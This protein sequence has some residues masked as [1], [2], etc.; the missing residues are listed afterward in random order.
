MIFY[1]DMHIHTP[2]SVCCSSDTQ[3][4]D[5]IIPLLARKGYKKIG[6]IDHVWDSKDVPPSDFYVTQDGKKHL[7]LHKFIHSREWEIEVWVG[8]E[9]DM[10]APGVFGITHELKE[11]LDYVAMATN[12]FHLKDFVEQPADSTPRALAQHMLKFFISAAESGLPDLLVHPFYPYGNIDIYDDTI[13]CLSDTELI[14]AFSVAASNN[15]A[16]EINKCYLPQLRPERLFSI[17]TP[18]RILT[19]AKQAGCKFSLG[20]DAHSLET[21]VV[22]DQLQNLAKTLN[23]TKADIH[24]IAQIR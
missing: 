20:S 10:K 6:F 15:I 22:L 19:L 4:P 12:H 5:N 21:F 14:D 11:K 13:S 16:I 3:I 17:E 1:S 9:A 24:P 2:A 18:L 8:C 23:I 7:E